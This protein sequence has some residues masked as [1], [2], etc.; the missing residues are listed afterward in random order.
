MLIKLAVTVDL[1]GMFEAALENADLTG[2]GPNGTGEY[3]LVGVAMDEVGGFLI[4]AANVERVEGANASRA[5]LT[6][7]V[8]D[9]LSNADHVETV[10]EA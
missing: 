9:A 2:L 6:E 3:E 5:D 8:M 10:D 7:R 1:A 4:V